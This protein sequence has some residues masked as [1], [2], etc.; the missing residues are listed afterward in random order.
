[1][2]PRSRRTLTATT[3]YL[4]ASVF[5]IGPA[6]ALDCSAIIL[7]KGGLLAFGQ[8]QLGDPR[9]RVPP[10]AVRARDCGQTCSYADNA[11]TTYLVKGDEIIRKEIPDVARYSGALPA[12][13]SASDSLQTI[14]KRLAAFS[15]GAP[16]WSLN[17]LP[18]G[19]LLLRTDN[20]IEGRNGVRGSYGF[21]FDRD[22]RLSAISAE[23]L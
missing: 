19:G 16:I 11:G 6:T 13:I 20:C 1:M 4:A 5:A 3:L 12:H 21:T 2:L 23:I 22:G 8:A 9:S 14:L 17:P 18:G 10:D 7:D 15:E